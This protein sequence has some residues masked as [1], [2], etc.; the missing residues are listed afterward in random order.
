MIAELMQLDNGDDVPAIIDYLSRQ[1]ADGDVF[2]FVIYRL[3]T[4]GYFR[5]PFLVSKMLRPPHTTH[6][7]VCFARTLGGIVFNRLEDETAG[8]EDLQ[9]AVSGLD[10]NQRHVLKESVFDPTLKHFEMNGLP[11]LVERLRI[12]SG[13]LMS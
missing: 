11:E 6:P 12:L 5:V 13:V 3:L 7:I 9:S 8:M 2:I 1:A 4:Q 10:A